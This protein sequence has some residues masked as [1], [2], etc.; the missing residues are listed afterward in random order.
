M[1][2]L[3]S[4]EKELTDRAEEISTHDAKRDAALA[5]FESQLAADRAE[6]DRETARRAEAFSTL[7]ERLAVVYNRLAQRSRDGIAVAEVVNGSCSACFMALRPQVQ[8]E[9]KRGDEIIVCESCSRI[10]FV[11]NREAEASA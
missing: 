4:V 6:F 8:V 2:E 10:L 11:P 3:E 9:V 5:E 7:Q 1:E